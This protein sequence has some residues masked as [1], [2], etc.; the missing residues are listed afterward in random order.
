MKRVVVLLAVLAVSLPASLG[1]D[2]LDE[3]VGAELARRHIPGLALAVLRSGQPP[4]LRA[5]GL[6]SLELA[7][8]VTP[9]TAF[10]MASVTKPF[11]AT[12]IMM[13]VTDGK[14]ALDAP[15]SRYVDGTPAAWAAIKV[16]HLLTHTSGIA[17]PRSFASLL[18]PAQPFLEDYTTRQMFEAATHDAVR[19][20]PG[21]RHVYRDTN[22]FL[23]GMIIERVS[24][25]RYGEFLARRIFR[26]LGMT[27]TTVPDSWQIVP[28]RASGYTLRDGAPARIRRDAQLELAPHTGLFSSAVDLA[29]FDAALD[30]GRVLP[31]AALE[32]MWT[33]AP[34]N[35][36]SRWPY[37]FGWILGDRRGHRVVKHSGITGVDYVKLPDDGLTVIALTN[38]G[39][40]FADVN[41][42]VNSWLGELLAGR[43]VPG[44]FASAAARRP[45]PAPERAQRYLEALA[46]FARGEIP[47]GVTA[48]LAAVLRASEA[49]TRRRIEQRLTAR[50]SFTYITSDDVRG[51]ALDRFGVPIARLDHYELA[52]DREKR[53]YTFAVTGDERLA[54]IESNTE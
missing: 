36:G 20:A 29:K 8:P 31:R 25:E 4:L 19:F 21:E 24:G 11:T 28:R 32:Q 14:L 18:K 10:D 52:T 49:G 16:R 22:Y 51:R 30:G 5:Y 40:L 17:P 33:P 13:L 26:P 46:A 53:Y 6:A 45:D 3:F 27:S 12:A 47:A 54:D 38:L 23:L 43:W 1:A 2:G 48:P 37:G 35:D 41:P 39:N 44:L 7:A 34:L 50:R 9:D 15:I 42:E